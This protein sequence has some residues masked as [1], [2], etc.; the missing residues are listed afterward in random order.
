MI[1]D[2]DK[3]IDRKN[4]NSLKFDF[5]V[6]RGKPKDIL[7][8]WVA[9]MDFATPDEVI[10]ALVKKAEHGVFGY[11]EPKEEYFKAL[12]NWFYTR[13][14]WNIDTSKV[15]LS[16]GVVYAISTLI[17][18]V[19]KHNDSVIICQPVYYPFQESIVENGRKLIVSKLI[20]NN[21]YYSM[22]FDDFEKKIIENDVKMFIMCSPHNPVGRVWTRQELERISQICLKHNVFVVA[23]EI[24]AD[25]VYDDNKHI[26]YS[27]LSKEAEMNCAVCTAPSKTFNLA[28]L[29]NA[30]I[31]IYDDKIR[32]AYLTV[33]N[34]HGYSQSNV[35]GIVGCQAA[36]T[37]GAE[38][39]DQLLV[40]L[41]SNINYLIEFIK[42]NLPKVKVHAPQGT[43]LVWLDFNEYNLSDRQLKDLIVDK[44]GLWLD[45][46]YIFGQGGS[47]FQRINIACPRSTL[48]TALEKIADVFKQI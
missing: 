3:V 1:Y 23:D 32:S 20:N 47:G 5:A 9:D 36:Y 25:F 31:Y 12:H 22:D 4:T 14:G 43:Y 29:H 19:T 21:G 16:C 48:T 37:Y 45:D 8:L 38:W 15:V 41:K 28:G 18:A 11:S 46:G 27:T 6:E 2:F 24:H 7:P 33:Q 13:H 42:S 26:V 17:C 35:F 10:K 30:N 39:L 34:S 40:Y 44:C